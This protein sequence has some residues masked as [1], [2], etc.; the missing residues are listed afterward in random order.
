MEITNERLMEI[1][2]MGMGKQCCRYIIVDPDEGFV[3][4]KGTPLQ[5]TLDANVLTMTAQGDN[6]EGLNNI[7]AEV[8]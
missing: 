8:A 4:A 6:C 2:K 5:V 3:C 7:P 1:C